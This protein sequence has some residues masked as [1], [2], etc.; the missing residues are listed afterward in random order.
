MNCVRE[1]RHRIER[2]LQTVEIVAHFHKNGMRA[3]VLVVA[4]L[5]DG[6]IAAQS[7]EACIDCGGDLLGEGEIPFVVRALALRVVIAASHQ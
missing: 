3:D 4:A 7:G 1:V 2:L 6:D 5:L